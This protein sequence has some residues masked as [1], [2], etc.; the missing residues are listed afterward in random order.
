[1]NSSQFNHSQVSEYQRGLAARRTHVIA[2][3][4][5][6]SRSLPPP[7]A[8]A[9]I[10]ALKVSTLDIAWLAGDGSD[11]CYYRLFSPQLPKPL[12][13]MQLS[14]TDVEKLKAGDYDWIK[15]ERILSARGVRVP[16]VVA[17]LKE[18]GAIVIQDYGD[19]MLEGRVY[20]LAEKND[21]DGVRKLYADGAAII[22]RM[23]KINEEKGAVWCGRSF[24]AERY[25]WELK[26]FAQKY[27]QLAAGITLTEEEEGSF[28]REVHSLAHELGQLSHSF[29]HRDFHSRNVMVEDDR[30]AII[31]FQDARLGSP[32]Y[33]LVSLYFDSYVP[34]SGELRKS[35]LEEGFSVL[36]GV[37][38]IKTV[39]EMRAW[40]KP[41][42]LQRQLK[43]IG[44]FGYLTLDRQRGDYL[45]YVG[46]AI[47]TLEDSDVGDA[48]W[49]FLSQELVQRVR[50]RLP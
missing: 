30:L 8:S 44:S 1:M 31:D 27:L 36:E 17:V 39:D 9:L 25:I 41:V 35:L 20:D 5:V 21:F 40:W 16:A 48:R 24:D 3:E 12:V 34:F 18:H 45:K 26:F 29:V 33:D 38:G 4:G 6:H 23:L 46:P 2:S 32:A 50:Q 14:G 22:G 47:K 7:P 42:L 13:L 43:A 37:V 28:D 11:R 49:P 10:K 15:V 19:V